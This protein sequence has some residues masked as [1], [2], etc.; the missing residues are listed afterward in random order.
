VL[1]DSA[2]DLLLREGYDPANGARPLRRSIQRL[3]TR[4]LSNAILEEKYQAGDAIRVSAQ[5]DTLALHATHPAA[6]A[7]T[8]DG[9]TLDAE[10]AD[11]NGSEQAAASRAD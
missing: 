2:R 3:L 9:D 6:H 7:A 1:D 5:D 11:E 8:P 10:D 4:P